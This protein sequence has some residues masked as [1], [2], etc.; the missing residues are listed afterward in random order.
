MSKNQACQV[1]CFPVENSAENKE[2][3]GRES[4]PGQLHGTELRLFAYICL[5]G[6]NTAKID[7]CSL[8][9]VA[10]SGVFK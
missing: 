9:S 6:K 7:G 1:F 4:N 2:C 10:A 8:L 5:E 3:V